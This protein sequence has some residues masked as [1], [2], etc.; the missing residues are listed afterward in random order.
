MMKIS[1]TESVY[2]RDRII[3]FKKNSAGFYTM[4]KS[5]TWLKRERE[6]RNFKVAES[7]GLERT[8]TSM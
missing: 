3:Y 2:D 1:W 5:F 7:V 8:K 6:G 4:I